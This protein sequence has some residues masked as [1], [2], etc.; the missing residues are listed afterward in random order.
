MAAGSLLGV[1][2]G[3][4]NSFPV[5]KVDFLDLHPLGYIEFLEAVGEDKLADL[6]R[7]HDWVLISNFKNRYQALLRQYYYVGGMPEAVSAFSRGKDFNEVRRLQQN[8]LT[9]YEQDFSKHAPTS[10]VARVR[11]LWNSIPSQLAKEN[12]KFIYGLIRTGAR[13]KE[14]EQAMAWLIDSG[15]VHKVHNVSKPAIPLKAYEELT[16]FKL[17]LVDVGLLAAMTALGVKTLIDGNEIFTEFKGALTEQYV[18]QKLLLQKPEA[19][20]HWAPENARSEIDFVIQN[21]G[22]IIPIEVKAE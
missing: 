14:Y 13:A 22:Q 5:G 16:A 6:L 2:L 8:I 3:G 4:S 12:R 17:F 19:T 10:I 18:L 11:M 20:Y 7:S 21:T 1:A 9:S 15:L